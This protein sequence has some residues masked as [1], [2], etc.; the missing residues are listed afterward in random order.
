MK[1]SLIK[2]FILLLFFPVLVPVFA[3]SSAF[4]RLDSDPKALAFF[5]RGARGYTWTDLAEI[6]LW[7]SGADNSRLDQIRSHAAAI[8]G[9]R[10]FP[11]AARER[12]EYIL[13]YMHRNLLKSYSLE[14]TRVDTVFSNGR[15]NCVSSGVLYMILCASVNLETSGVM[16]KDHAFVMVLAD[17]EI[18]DVET[19]NPHGFDPGSRREFHDEFGKLTGF[20]YVPARDYRDRQALKPVELISLIFTNRL[21]AL[22]R[23][24]RFAEAVPLAIDRMVLLTGGNAG[25]GKDTP[26]FQDPRMDLL[27]R[28]LN[29]GA[30]LLGA[31][32]EDECLRWASLAIP[33]YPD[34]RRWQELIFAAANNRVTKL[35]RAGRLPAARDFLDA[36]QAV[37]DPALYAQLDAALLDAELI[38]RVNRIR[39]AAEGD[40][41]ITAIDQAR[42]NNRMEERRAA[43]LLSVAVEKSAAA[44]SARRDWLAAIN[45]V[46]AAITRYGSSRDLEQTLRIY[47]NNRAVDF[48]NSFA[49]AWNRRNYDEARRILNDALAEFPG[50]RQ[51]L[52]DRETVNRAGR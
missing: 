47:R 32:K 52:A 6:S 30:S 17:G 51:L 26:F 12:A 38:E 41:V 22:E 42:S 13:R 35:V 21:S 3:Q 10:D 16:T 25:A 34:A 15:Y 8:R 33:R 28:L 18:I 48:H 50:D 4:P 44:L 23:A 43:E 24:N 27:D 1:H 19:T 11:A 37:L 9:A 45:Y 20:A 40:S 14:Q 31:G 29:Y 36:Q 49:A 2:C 5:E 46:E 39:G 7:A